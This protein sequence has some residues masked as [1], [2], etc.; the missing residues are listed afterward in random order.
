MVLCPLLLLAVYA[1]YYMSS[2]AAIR[3]WAVSASRHRRKEVRELLDDWN[4][5]YYYPL[6]LKWEVGAQG[7][8]LVLKELKGLPVSNSSGTYVS[9]GSGRTSGHGQYGQIR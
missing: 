3:R 6:N 2:K 8:W 4:D 5:S 1:I 7:A 9:F